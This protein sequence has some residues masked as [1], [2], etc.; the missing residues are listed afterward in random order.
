M[1]AYILL[2]LLSILFLGSCTKDE[3]PAP[4]APELSGRWD[5]R[6]VH[7]ILFNAAGD[8][9]YQLKDTHA[10]AYLLFARDNTY[11][12]YSGDVLSWSGT[13]A[14][15]DNSLTLVNPIQGS[16][17]FTITTLSAT[18]LVLLSDRRV[19]KEGGITISRYAKH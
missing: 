19:G 11:D 17:T 5:S 1:R 16:Q 7:L 18:S 12:S 2:L 13:Y 8:T 4:P 6:G 10:N 15:Q 9:T 14:R 3:E